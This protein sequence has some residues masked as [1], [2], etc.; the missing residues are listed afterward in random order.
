M[1]YPRI[2]NGI[3][4]QD[5][6]TYLYFARCFAS[7]LGRSKYNR[8]R[9]RNQ[10]HRLHRNDMKSVTLLLLGGRNIFCLALENRATGA[11]ILGT[12]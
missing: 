1:H 11:A 2:V 12:F 9:K 6:L 10:I 4:V 5:F 8:K 7:S 3:E